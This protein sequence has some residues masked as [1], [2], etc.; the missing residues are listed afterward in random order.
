MKKA[1]I[2]IGIAALLSFATI[3]TFKTVEDDDISYPLN[4][5]Q[6]C[7]SSE[8][9]SFGVE[10]T[11]RCNSNQQFVVTIENG[12]NTLYTKCL[13]PNESQLFGDTR[14]QT[15]VGTQSC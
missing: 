2:L 13:G 15:S 14:A 12:L 5:F 4:Q 6:F 8:T 10:I 3:L 9:T 11:N 7:Y 1:L